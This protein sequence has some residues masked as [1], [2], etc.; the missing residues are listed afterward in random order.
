MPVLVNYKRCNCMPRCFAANACPKDALKVDLSLMKVVVTPEVCGTCPAPCLNFCDAVALKYAPNLEELDIMQREMDGLISVDAALEER[1]G[2]AAKQKALEAA[3]QEEKELA[4]VTPVKLTM[5]NFMQEV[6][7]NELPVL[8]DFWAEWCGP[9]KQIAPAI[10]ELAR[11]FAGLIKFAKLNVDEVPQL[12]SQLGIQSIPTLL[13]FFQGQLAD[14][15]VGAVGKDQLR[16]RLQRVADEIARIK[17]AATA[18]P[19]APPVSAPAKPAPTVRPT[20]LKPNGQ[21]RPRR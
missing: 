21:P 20:L 9:C 13:I 19:K 10:E 1:K 6:I 15:I 14:K 7:Q 3:A 12:S 17:A 11:E 4:A 8:V 16:I 18:D 2:L 5:E